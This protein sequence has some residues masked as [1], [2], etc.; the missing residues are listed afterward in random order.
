MGSICALETLHRQPTLTVRTRTSVAEIS[1]ALG[2]AF[3]A[4]WEY[5]RAHDVQPAG[6]PFALYHNMDMQ[7]LDL[8][9]GYPVS[10]SVR[11]SAIVIAGEL[12]E[13]EAATCLHI[14][15]YESIGQSYEVLMNWMKE[16]SLESWGLVYEFYLN[17]PRNTP[18]DQLRTRIVFPL[19]EVHA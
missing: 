14:G 6:P 1:N 13:C 19:L 10:R 3:K 4:V 17:D 12:P 9:A 5:A 16:R 7:D 8:E 2:T 18:P 11:G 15:S